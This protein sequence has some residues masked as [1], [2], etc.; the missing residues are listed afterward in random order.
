MPEMNFRE[1]HAWNSFSLRWTRNILLSQRFEETRCNYRNVVQPLLPQPF[2][3][4]NPPTTDH[5]HY[6]LVDFKCHGTATR[7]SK[8]EIGYGISSTKYCLEFFIHPRHLS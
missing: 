6:P 1:T 2:N 5:F 4:L 7:L 8:Q 3:D